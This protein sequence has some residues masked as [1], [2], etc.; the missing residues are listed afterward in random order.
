MILKFL[1]RLFGLKPIRQK[2]RPR[3]TTP[4]PLSSS[5]IQLPQKP[6]RRLFQIRSNGVKVYAEP[7][8]I[9]IKQPSKKLY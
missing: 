7:D 1:V 8:Y 6:K 2:R 9:S 5:L 3:P 4:Q